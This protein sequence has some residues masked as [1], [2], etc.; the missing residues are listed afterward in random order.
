MSEVFYLIIIFIS[1]L[2]A[3]AAQRTKKKIFLVLLIVIL[4]IVAGFRGS[5]VGID[6]HSYYADIQ[7]RFPYSWHFREE[8]FRLVSNS[9]MD[10][11]NNPQ[12]VFVF[13]AFVTNL[14]IILRLWDFREDTRFSFVILL[15]LLLFYSDSMNIMRQYVAVALMFYGTR[16][17]KKKKLLAFIPFLVIAFFF[18][19]SSLLGVGYIAINLWVS[20]SKKQKKLFAIPMILA[21]CGSAA[22][23]AM[24]LR[25]D[26]ASYFSQ[27]IS[28]INIPFI[29]RVLIA[30]FVLYFEKTKKTILIGRP[31][32]NKVT[33]E[34]YELDK[35]ITL[36]YF[37][38]LAFT[39][40]SMFYSFVGRTGLFYMMYE[41]VF[42]GL[43]TKK[44][45]SRSVYS[46]LILILAVYEFAVLL[47][48]NS[49][50]LF[51]YYLYL[52]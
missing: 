10:F 14:L 37:I 41:L 6:T 30:A 16:Y 13:C 18:H 44:T 17:L 49:V 35:G 21:L 42:W 4:T 47:I 9:I 11:T 25:R 33:V 39:A 23:V 2:L 38:G 45:K 34:R 24:Y 22:Y 50:G 28:N 19:R 32:K 26:I 51:P 15:Y 3:Y 40:L 46:I 12:I 36:Y 8:G 5:T 29:Y 31:R 43:V 52:Y 1:Y 27:S 20:F 48:R 7:A